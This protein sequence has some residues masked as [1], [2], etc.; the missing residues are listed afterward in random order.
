MEKH[1]ADGIRAML[2]AMAT[3]TRKTVTC[4]GFIERMLRNERFNRILFLVDRLA[5]GEQA[6]EKFKSEIVHGVNTLAQIYDVATIDKPRIDATTRLHIATVQSMVHRL[7]EHDSGQSRLDPDLYD[8]IVVDECHRGYS[9]DRSMTPGELEFRSEA[10]YQSD[11]R[12][13]L[14]HFDV[15]KIGLTATPAAHTVAIFGAPIYTCGGS[16]TLH[17][18]LDLR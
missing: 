15:V 10:E 7:T 2:V 4:L 12:R 1:I 6:E 16:R 18:G 11:Y 5:L 8:C 17:C 14:D 3:G 13:V 9:L